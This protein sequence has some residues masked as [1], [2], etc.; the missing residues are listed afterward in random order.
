[1]ENTITCPECGSSNIDIQVFQENNGSKTITKTKS[2]YKEKR[3]GCLWWLC[4]GWWW[5]IVDLA[6]WIFFFIPRV[7]LSIARKRNYKGKSK[8]TSKTVNDID[9]K[10][11]G[12]CMSCGH[13]W[14]VGK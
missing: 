14:E 11:I 7:L 4:M 12:V 5:W 3:H 1:M 6:I 8:S 13:H 9:Y 10:S 2:K